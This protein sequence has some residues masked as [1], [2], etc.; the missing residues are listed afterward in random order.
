MELEENKN[1]TVQLT[2]RERIMLLGLLP[3]KGSLDVIR[4][5]KKLLEKLNFS[6]KDVKKIGL[7]K[8]VTSEGSIQYNWSTKEEFLSSLD[9][10][11]EEINVFDKGFELISQA[12]Q[13]NDEMLNLYE[14][15]KQE[16]I[17]VNSKNFERRF[18]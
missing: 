14:K 11:P 8:E 16:L 1:V 7:K 13:F 12:D 4:A 17:Q 2:I 15:L 3:I 9:F 5:K 18:I 6:D 10:T